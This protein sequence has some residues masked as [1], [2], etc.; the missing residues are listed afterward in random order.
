MKKDKLFF[1]LL[2]LFQLVSVRYALSQG[3]K[4]VP[5]FATFWPAVK[6]DVTR[7]YGKYSPILLLKSLLIGGPFRAIFSMRLCQAVST[8]PAPL[9]LSLTLPCRILHYLALQMTGMDIGWDCVIG[10]GVWINHGWGLVTGHGI[11][12]GGGISIGS[13][14]TLFHGVTIGMQHKITAEGRVRLYPKIE[15]EV[16][17]GPH[18]VVTGDVV[19]GRGS[20]IA[21][22]TVVTG[23]VEP[24]SIVG[25]N[26]MRVIQ[27]NALPD[28][29]NPADIFM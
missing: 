6:T 22:G 18:A 3:R 14:V 4:K 28:V 8:L 27:T 26:P 5:I 13:N 2:L 29:M 20:R 23:N 17:I 16:W 7:I 10:P 24:Y 1:F 9:S 11:D 15:D 19:I 12:K 21:P 25:G